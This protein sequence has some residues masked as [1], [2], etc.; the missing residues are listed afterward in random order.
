VNRKAESA[1]LKTRNRDRFLLAFEF[2]HAAMS[3]RL[4]PIIRSPP[5]CGNPSFFSSRKQIQA[6]RPAWACQPSLGRSS[7]SLAQRLIGGDKRLYDG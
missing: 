5:I 3:D 6:A 2:V 1:P 4:E 7:A